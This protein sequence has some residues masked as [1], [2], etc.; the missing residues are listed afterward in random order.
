MKNVDPKIAR[1]QNSSDIVFTGFLQYCIWLVHL[2][3]KSLSDYL[4][5]FLTQGE[6]LTWGFIYY[7]SFELKLISTQA[8]ISVTAC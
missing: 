6:K 2:L 8:K 7:L 1:S 3:L 5:I 4:Y